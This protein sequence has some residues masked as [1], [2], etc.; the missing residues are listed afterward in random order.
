[1]TAYGRASGATAGKEYTVELR[2]VNNRFLDC[3]VRLPR[4]YSYLEDKVRTLIQQ[5]GISRG[6]LEVGISIN[7]LASEGVSVVLDEAYAD[8]YMAA[9]RQLRDRFSLSDDITVMQAAQN[10]DLFVIR[11]PEEDAEKEWEE[12]KPVLQSAIDAFNRM[13]EREG[14]NLRKD[15]LAKK[16]RVA[17]LAEQIR[18]LSEHN[19]EAYRARLEARLRQTLAGLDIQM[20]NA[21]ILT[22]CAIFADKIAVDEE[23]V[24][25]RS[26]FQAFD[27]AFESGE[28]VGRRIDFLLQE[29]NREINTTGSKSGD[30]EIAQ[31]VVDAKC[32]LEKIREQIQNLE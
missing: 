15:L 12:L 25:L 22:E 32:E 23:M 10:R 13:R 27:K 24:R 19:T 29:M 31:L 11:K 28:P 21:R 20:D 18:I 26:H 17:A 16:D 14:E 6:K 9:L 8:S 3:T 2:S 4:A 30:A 5:N 1:M 7:V